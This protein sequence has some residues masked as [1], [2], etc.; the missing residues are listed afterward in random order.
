MFDKLKPGFNAFL[1]PAMKFF[2][3]LGVHP[4]HIT[5]FGVV[6]FAGAGF[7][8]ALGGNNY[9]LWA[10]ALLVAGS[11]M[12]GIDGQLA[13]E[14]GKKSVFGSI[15]DSSCDRITEILFLAGLLVFYMNDPELHAWGV[16]LCYATIASSVM[17]SYVK[18]CCDGVGVK[19]SRGFMQRPE[20]LFLFGT[21]L[22]FGPVAML[23]ILGI[24]SLLGTVTAMERL[25][26]AAIRCKRNAEV[27]C[28]KE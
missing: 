3:R 24:V 25:V 2:A 8:S 21:G 19:C 10:F 28:Q 11:F 22:V 13:R 4:N 1:R 5:I 18:A 14:Y 27:P 17:V 7:L 9:W 20:R 16:Y 26:G 6:L 15:L 12:D 23:W